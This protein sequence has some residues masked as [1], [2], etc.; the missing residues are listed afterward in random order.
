[1]TAYVITKG[2][3]WDYHICT[4]T[5]DKEKAERLARMYSDK[6]GPA[7]IEEYEVDREA[8]VN[9]LNGRIPYE[10]IFYKNGKH[11]L[12]LNEYELD[13]FTERV[14]Y[15]HGKR[16]WGNVEMSVTVYAENE[17]KAFKIAADKRTQYLAEK[18]EII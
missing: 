8:D 15:T 14:K 12:C 7:G 11:F 3:Y 5:L 18:A 4:V 6:Y 1:M 10:V 9:M 2:S 16:G 13:T 17:E